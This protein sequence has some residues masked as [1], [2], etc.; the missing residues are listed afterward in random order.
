MNGCDWGGEQLTGK[1]LG[2]AVLCT[3]SGADAPVPLILAACS[4]DH[5]YLIRPGH[6]GDFLRAHR[7][8]EIACHDVGALHWSI[9]GLL[10]T[11]GDV[12][13]E[14]LLWDYSRRDRLEDVGLL[15]QLVAMAR[16]GIEKDYPDLA[17]LAQR[18]GL[19]SMTKDGKM[20]D[21]LAGEAGMPWE[22]ISPATR[23]AALA[24]A[25]SIAATHDRL[26]EEA[27][28]IYSEA[29]P[30]E[31]EEDV[32]I[33]SLGVQV[34]GAIALY[35]ASRVG[36]LFDKDDEVIPRLRSRCE[37]MFVNASKYLDSKGVVSRCFQRD[38]QEL[39]R[40]KNG[41][42]V[43]RKEPLRVWLEE[44]LRSSPGIHDIAFDPPRSEEGQ[45][46][47]A[48]IAWGDLVDTDP[49][50]QAWA[51][52]NSAANVQRCLAG[53]PHGAML[54]SSY[55]T[56][57]RI[58]ARNPDPKQLRT[59]SD[60]PLFVPPPGKAMLVVEL[61]DLELR[62]LANAR[63]LEYEGGELTALFKDGSGSARP[64]VHAATVLYHK[65]KGRDSD[66]DDLPSPR[67]EDPRLF[68]DFQVIAGAILRAAAKGMGPLQA[69]RFLT[70]EIESRAVAG[71]FDRSYREVIV[72]IFP[73]IDWLLDD[74]PIDIL[75]EK[76][77]A[78]F[79]ELIFMRDLNYPKK[80]SHIIRETIAGRIERPEIWDRMREACV[81][82]EYREQ[83]K[84]G[85]GSKNLHDQLFIT[86]VET[87][88]GRVR[89][90]VPYY[91]TRLFDH[92]D[93]ADDVRKEVAYAIV[94][95]GFDLAGIA[96]DE[97]ILLTDDEDQTN[98][99]EGKAD[100]L[101]KKIDLEASWPLGEI[102]L[103]SRVTP[104]AAW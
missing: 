70:P 31:I 104:R 77:K 48:S 97:F 62:C 87:G 98:P 40:R 27:R 49:H 50:L 80:T 38:N 84:R 20:R 63:A 17:D 11:S 88:A 91:R 45:V 13:A 58:S 74:W 101:R 22:G 66:S 83:L 103:G 51:T 93:L 8:A 82:P 23:E 29:L 44:R 30:D 69:R 102:P 52:L 99:A 78:D 7:S 79:R 75:V 26:I 89:G 53:L 5:R 43:P 21:R 59:F 39:I 86:T 37:S 90:S 46:A 95:A 60:S 9:S 81:D 42:V 68:E 76:F 2:L 24:D 56:L 65:R 85:K 72:S 92:R 3:E 73:E 61:P 55:Q 25:I 47:I 35:R 28:Q 96:G 33:F 1:T 94:E 14:G 64:I 10:R 57:P 100:H 12:E 36:L 41:R 71:D 34:R 4:G 15:D 32:S 67:D 18:H 6:I 54:R 19:V 16:H